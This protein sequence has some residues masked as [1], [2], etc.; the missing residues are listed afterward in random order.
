M[1]APEPRN[2][3]RAVQ[4]V[5]DGPFWLTSKLQSLG[6]AHLLAARCWSLLALPT[7]LTYQKLGRDLIGVNGQSREMDDGRVRTLLR[8]LETFVERFIQT[9]TSGDDRPVSWFPAEPIGSLS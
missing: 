8:R 2:A 3:L 5:A 7:R 6:P 9:D 1:L 4:A